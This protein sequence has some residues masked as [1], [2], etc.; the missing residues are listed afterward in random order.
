MNEPH[1]PSPI[2]F[3]EER[4][5]RMLEEHLRDTRHTL[6]SEIAALTAQVVAGNLQSATEYAKVHA[7]L[8]FVQRDLAELKPLKDEVAQLQ[9]EDRKQAALWR[10]AITVSTLIVAAAGVV[11]A[12][13]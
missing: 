13:H 12:L 2:E 3:M 1:N 10:A 7:A 6:R 5:R 8:E 4:M 11:V 9:S